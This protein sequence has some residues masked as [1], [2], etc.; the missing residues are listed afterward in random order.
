ML[1]DLV[2]EDEADLLMERFLG[3]ANDL[4]AMFMMKEMTG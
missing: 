4:E 3:E 1:L 2:V